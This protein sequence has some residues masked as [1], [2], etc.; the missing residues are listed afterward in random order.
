MSLHSNLVDLGS[1]PI[2][3]VE[4]TQ[5]HGDSDLQTNTLLVAAPGNG[6]TTALRALYVR[7]LKTGYS[8]DQ[9]AVITPTRA[10]ANRLRDL[11]AFDYPMASRWPRAR[12]IHSFAHFLVN[13]S[14]ALPS[15]AT[16]PTLLSGAQQ[17]HIIDGL[18][19]E[20]TD[21]QLANL[22]LN[23]RVLQL[24]GFRQE[25]RD[26]LD[27]AQQHRLSDEQIASLLITQPTAGLQ[28][29]SIIL[30][31]Y[32]D[33]LDA[34]NFLD[35]AA[36]LNF[37]TDQI[38]SY[39]SVLDR[40]Q[41]KALL[42]DD[43][44]DIPPAGLELIAGVA[45]HAVVHAF[46]DPDASVLG[47]RSASPEAL[48]SQLQFWGQANSRQSRIISAEAMRPRPAL[49]VK[50]LASMAEQI[51]TSQF[52]RHRPRVSP[53]QSLENDST[54]LVSA[55]FESAETESRWLAAELRHLHFAEQ[56]PWHEMAVVARSRSELARLESEFSNL[57]V[58]CR[59][60]GQQLPLSSQQAAGALLELIWH[61]IG[62][63][64]EGDHLISLLRS[65]ILGFSAISIARLGRQLR[66]VHRLQ[67]GELRSSNALIGDALATPAIGR[68]LDTVE[69]DQISRLAAVVSALRSS[70]YSSAHQM[71]TEVWKLLDLADGWV[72][73]ANG[74]G[75]LAAA[76]N[77]NLDSIIH[78][79]TAA[80]RFD[81]RNSAHPP[82]E[83]VR[84]QRELSIPEDAILPAV[85]DSRVALA[86][87][88]SVVGRPSVVALPGLQAG[89]WPNLRQRGSMLGSA[90]LDSFLR[91]RSTDG[92]LAARQ[93]LADERRMLYRCLGSAA[94]RIIIS[95]RDSLDESPSIFFSQLS[96]SASQPVLR[97]NIMNLRYQ[98]GA[99]RRKVLVEKSS[100]AAAQLRLLAE[101]GVPGAHP[102]NWHH[103]LE[104]ST[105][106]VA[107][108][109]LQVT[110]SPSQL[111]N[112]ETCPLH[113]F[114][115]AFGGSARSSEA[116][117]GT[118]I[119]R[120]L[121]SGASNAD[122][123][124]SVVESH[125]GEISFDSDWLSKRSKLRAKQLLIN[126][127][128]YL[129]SEALPLLE[130]EKLVVAQLSDIKI[131]GRIDR[132]EGRVDSGL[133]VV[134]IK[135][136]TS[137]SAIEA[138]K[139]RQLQLYQLALASQL[140]S[141]KVAGARIV[142][143]SGDK[144][145]VLSQPALDAE[146]IAQLHGLLDQFREALSRPR[147]SA[148]V[149]THCSQD[150]HGCGWL[151]GGSLA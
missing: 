117:L 125:W 35:S 113:W 90:A 76:A 27:V 32:R 53:E 94:D 93:E 143:I 46:G 48:H 80:R 40:L 148:S 128:Q 28:L 29:L 47:F 96:E 84:M 45:S 52:F 21:F 43:I 114:I 4:V 10:T 85:T 145:K 59:V 110:V 6:K 116:T 135:T 118:L 3:Q 104:L 13:Q 74:T 67:T 81:E 88:S 108:Q 57:G 91:G 64:A 103:Q 7:L 56:I 15:V 22:S 38:A 49:I 136:G 83:F 33:L 75:P 137:P 72:A 101:S 149:T 34:E 30:P 92:R 71:V 146:A 70:Q 131:V 151:I 82:S 41:I 17:Q 36:L 69:G 20:L 54:A 99:L 1:L 39:P 112:F 121:E 144:Y 31:K 66:E 122:D 73:T 24:Q 134:D 61:A 9:V 23:R 58:P 130:S 5:F 16:A 139:S 124:W 126:L 78:L 2:D 147:L 141:G 97:Q 102:S 120:A 18:L 123:L 8:C 127:S 150:A 138:A 11:L 26:L 14:V 87:P 89:L 51:P 77:R 100:F 129:T 133:Q 98:V 68:E 119:H 111:G 79:F 106:S 63:A 50:A 107:K 140:P 115:N 62:V 25:V 37:A 132:I 12:S 65:P 95:A 86:T 42:I 105:N 60:V 44:Q 142:S 19:K 55:I 109:Q